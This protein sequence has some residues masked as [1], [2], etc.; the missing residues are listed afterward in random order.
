MAAVL[1]ASSDELDVRL[2][3]ERD[4]VERQVD[5]LRR[6]EHDL[7]EQIRRAREQVRYYDSLVQRLKNDWTGKPTAGDVVRRLR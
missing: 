3:T 2:R 1:P 4:R 7:L 5:R 6:E